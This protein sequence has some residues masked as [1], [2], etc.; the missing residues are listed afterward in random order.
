MEATPEGHPTLVAQLSNLGN[1]LSR[2]YERTGD[3]KDLQAAIARSEAAVEAAPDDHPERAT[4]LNTLG[5]V[6]GS[7]MDELETCKT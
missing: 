5:S 2:R 6:S 1:Y 7:Y 4:H 3:M